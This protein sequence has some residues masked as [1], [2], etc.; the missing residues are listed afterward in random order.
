MTKS[1]I[2]LYWIFTLWACLGLTSTAL[3]PLFHLKG[4]VDF[5][6]HLG[7]PNYFL[8]LISI[9]KLLAVVALLVPG[10]PRVKEWTYA[11]LFFL[12][13]G[14]IFSHL[15][16]GDSFKELYQSL[17]EFS[18]IFVSWYFRPAGRKLILAHS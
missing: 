5:I 14:A 1:K 18:L 4:N 10:F 12:M 9:W 11:G 7:Y 17:L 8:T 3:V 16:M 2:I 6:T 13:T 15:A